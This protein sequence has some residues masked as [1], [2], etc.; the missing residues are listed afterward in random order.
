M[1]QQNEAVKSHSIVTPVLFLGLVIAIGG[2]IYESMRRE[3]LARDLARAQTTTSRQMSQLNDTTKAAISQAHQRFD[4]LESQV[5]ASDTD[6]SLRQLRSEIKKS[7]A[8]LADGVEQKRQQLI[9]QLADLGADTSEKLGRVSGDL[10]N[11]SADV[12]RVE[13]DLNTVNSTVATNAKELAALK[14]L[15]ERNYFEFALSKTKEP[16]KVGDVR[17]VLK[18]ADPKHNRYSIELL[19]DDKKVEKKDRTV[20]E[21]VQFYLSGSTQAYEIVV[22]EVKKD[23]VIGYV[24]MPKLKAR[25]QAS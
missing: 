25:G 15:A 4:A 7:T 3:D 17:L 8:Q 13:G 16:Q 1:S 24:V 11:T 20:N 12:K 14:E 9:S 10:E 5:E 22:N 6:V 2:N 23:K 19:A 18:N 21:P